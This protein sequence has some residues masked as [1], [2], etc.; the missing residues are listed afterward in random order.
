MP[1]LKGGADKNLNS[2]KVIHDFMRRQSP[3]SRALHKTG[4]GSQAW[5]QAVELPSHECSYDALASGSG[6]VTN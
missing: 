3:S 5:D 4:L 1:A 2:Q 6:F